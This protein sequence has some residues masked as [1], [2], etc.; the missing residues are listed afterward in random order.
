METDTPRSYE[1]MTPVMMGWRLTEMTPTEDAASI[2]REL[3]EAKAILDAVCFHLR[4]ND[5]R[6]PPTDS[7][8]TNQMISRIE[9]F[10]E[11]A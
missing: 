5:H 8:C 11:N 9:K 10:L 1:N 7:T 4:R 6:T 3:N 2:E